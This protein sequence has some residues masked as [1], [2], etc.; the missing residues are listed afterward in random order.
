MTEDEWG[1]SAEPT[2][3][4]RF[5]R[6]RASERKLRLLC[7]ACCRRVWHLLESESLRQA[8]DALEGFADAEIDETSFRAIASTTHPLRAY[9]DELLSGQVHHEK[10]LPAYG[11][12]RVVHGTL[13]TQGQIVF[14]T[15]RPDIEVV[16]LALDFFARA[17]TAADYH[18]LA[19]ERRCAPSTEERAAQ[20][21]L[22]RD[23]FG[24]SFPTAPE[25]D[26]AWLDSN[27]GIVTRLAAAI[28]ENRCLPEGTLEVERMAVLADALEEA[29]CTNQ[30]MLS[31]CRN[32]GMHVRGCWPLDLILGKQ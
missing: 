3:M 20:A 29:G 18:L 24:G 1:S 32:G 14:A 19:D 30:E 12:N 21:D 28:Y 13:A 9:H 25:I 27:D 26:S 11:I 22:I 23:L 10:W 16:T 17:I 8:V 6:V 5:L 2:V 4:L 15:L 7:G 31:H